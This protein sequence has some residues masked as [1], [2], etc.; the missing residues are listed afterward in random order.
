MIT[1]NDRDMITEAGRDYMLDIVL[2]SN[3]LKDKLS[4][5]QHLLLCDTVVNLPYEKVVRLLFTED[6]RA[7]E[8]KFGKFLK[9]SI[10]AIA[11]SKFG[12]ILHG[13]PVAMFILY[14]YRK[15]S[16]TCVRSCF[17]KMPLSTARKV[18]KYECQLN[19]A[20]KMAN[21]IRAEIVKCRQFER[22]KS[23]EKKLQKEW[24][25]W[26]KRVQRLLV[27]LNNAK[28]DYTEK[29][30]KARFN[31]LKGKARGIA[32]EIDL[33]SG[34]AANLIAESKELRKHLSFEQHIE[35][36]KMFVEKADY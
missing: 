25:K 4:F 1:Q 15:L 11:G 22:S 26:A 23:C 28:S 29:T 16:D 13:P 9:Y 8:G 12:G 31:A 17:K 6:I 30:R 33:S 10:A 19:A 20:R 35:L 34:D 18:C 2:E 24:T 32:G 21:D 5:K 27:K 7:F 3:I 14:L 36:Y